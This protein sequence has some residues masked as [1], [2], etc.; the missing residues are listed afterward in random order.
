MRST[1]TVMLIVLFCLTGVGNVFAYGYGHRGGGGYYGHGGAYGYGHGGYYGHA[2]YG[3]G[4][5]YGWGASIGLGF[6]PY[7]GA[8]YYA[9]GYYGSPY[10]SPIVIEQAGPQV[11][12]EQNPLPIQPVPTAGPTPTLQSGYWYYCRASKGYYPYVKDCRV[13]WERVSPLPPGQR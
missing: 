7:W 4:Y 8:G 9:P 13:G 1:K 3:R 6:A 2:Y 5:G 12:I 11:Y 10:Y